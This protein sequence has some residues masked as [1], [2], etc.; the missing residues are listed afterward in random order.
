MQDPIGVITNAKSG[1]NSR[2]AEAIDRA[3]AVF[4]PQ[5]RLVPWDTRADLGAIVDRLVAEGRRTI[6][7]AGGDGTV[8]AVAGALTGR[9]GVRMA[10]L[11]LGTFNF[12]ARGLGLPED[13]EGAARAILAGRERRISVGTVNGQVFL[14]NASV[15]IYPKILKEREA[16]Y[17]RWGRFRIAAH[18]SVVKTFLR[19]QSPMRIS[20]TTD[21]TERMLRTPLIFVARSAFQLERY[22]LGGAE[23]ISDDRF[24]LFVARGVETRAGL[25]RLT[26]RLVTG[27]MQEGRDV[28]LIAAREIDLDVSGHAALVAFDGEKSRMPLPLRFRIAPDA[29]TIIV[30]DS[31]PS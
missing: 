24:A 12:F 7:A 15:G 11:P 18:W 30:P 2:E 1:R 6:V 22:G 9:E 27:Q 13:P 19:F 3:M 4:G 16:V 25:F 28:E 26:W 17:G 21:G 10:A 5:A 29:L 8:T 23:A 14:N 20:L 31:D